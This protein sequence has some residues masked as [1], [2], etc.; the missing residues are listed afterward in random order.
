M[1]KF[2]EMKV[3]AIILLLI[4]SFQENGYSQVADFEIIAPCDSMQ[5]GY[6]METGIRLIHPTA[7]DGLR[8][9]VKSADPIQWECHP[10]TLSGSDFSILSLRTTDVYFT[11]EAGLEIVGMQQRDS[12]KKSLTFKVFGEDEQPLFA[13]EKMYLDQAVTYLKARFPAFEDLIHEVDTSSL[14]CY[15]PFPAYD[16]VNHSVLL[17]K[18][19]R[20]NVQEHVMV[21]PF[22]WKKIFLWNDHENLYFGVQIDTEGKCSLIPCEV[23]YYYQSTNFSPLDILLSDSCIFEDNDMNE[24]VGF[25]ST[26]DNFDTLSYHYRIVNRDAPFMISNGNELHANAVFNYGRDSIFHLDI[27]SENDFG[28]G[29]VHPFTIA[30]QQ[31]STPSGII[32][33]KIV[34]CNFFIRNEELHFSEWHLLI[35]VYD[36]T[37]RKIRTRAN[38][39]MISLEGLED[40]IVII[41][42]WD[43]N[44]VRSFKVLV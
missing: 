6:G 20:I 37:G 29:I 8:F 31:K 3:T 30:V 24:R 7:N 34:P 13:R 41:R 1:I 32:E 4:I 14:F 11:G 12:L 16:I 36:V 9:M 18:Y 28:Y 43:P 22:D 42:L 35:E 33:R 19:W 38:S 10:D 39:A 5:Y 21:P 44:T 15:R 27:L 40:Q 17:G 2:P 23:H 25:L 26:V